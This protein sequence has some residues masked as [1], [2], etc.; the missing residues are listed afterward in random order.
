[1]AVAGEATALR[2]FRS[3]APL[4]VI[5]DL[6]VIFIAELTGGLPTVSIHGKGTRVNTLP[7]VPGR[8]WPGG[9]SSD[10]VD[11]LSTIASMLAAWIK[12]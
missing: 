4:V 9:V 6:T 1:M 12:A 3:L 10:E 11:V 2:L 7:E 8:S 5:V